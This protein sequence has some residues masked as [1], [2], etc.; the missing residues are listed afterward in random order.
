[1]A[2]TWNGSLPISTIDYDAARPHASL[3]GRTRL[4]FRR[5]THVADRRSEPGALDLPQQWPRPAS[6]RLTTNSR[7]TARAIG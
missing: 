4:T 7:R 5:W 1:M 6:R 3:D 2:V